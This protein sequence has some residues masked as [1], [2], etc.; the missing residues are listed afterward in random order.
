MNRKTALV[1]GAN[2]G[3]GRATAKA[4]AQKGYHVIMACRNGQKGKAAMDEI[5]AETGGSVS[6][7]FCDLGDMES[8]RKACAAFRDAHQSLDVLINNAGIVPTERAETKHGLEMQFGVNHI[9]HF[10]LTKELLPVITQT[11][12]SRI[13]VVSSL[14]YRFGNID[15]QDI[16]MKKKYSTMAAYSRSKLCNVLFTKELARR[17]EGTATTVNCLHPGFVR[18]TLGMTGDKMTFGRK[19]NIWFMGWRAPCC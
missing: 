16:P 19:L 9:G 17:L 12:D 4:L 3:M 15:F 18:T 6:L 7:L 1:T 13:V 8:I 11:P 10:L 14:G 5:A 2:A